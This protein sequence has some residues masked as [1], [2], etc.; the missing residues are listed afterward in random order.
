MVWFARNAAS[1]CRTEG[2]FQ[3]PFIPSKEKQTPLRAFLLSGFGN[4]CTQPKGPREPPVKW[5]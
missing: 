5:T 2:N 3:M 4:R 1:I